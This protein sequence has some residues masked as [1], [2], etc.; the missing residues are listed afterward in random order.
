MSNTYPDPIQGANSPF[1]KTFSYEPMP[2][3]PTPVIPERSLR[4]YFAA[5]ALQAMTITGQ[6]TFSEYANDAY[7]LADAMLKA[8]GWGE[9]MSHLPDAGK[10]VSDTPRMD[11]VAGHARGIVDAAILDEG[12]KLERE[13]NAA[14]DRINRLEED[15]ESRW[16]LAESA[17]VSCDEMESR[18]KRLEEAGDA[19]ND[20]VKELDEK[21]LEVAARNLSNM[22]H[23]DGLHRKIERLIKAG[24]G[25]RAVVARDYPRTEFC[26]EW[27]KAK[28]AK[29]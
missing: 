6:Y 17:I 21:R 11:S 25:L 27:D 4:D 13:L 20:R 26:D 8:R 2:H 7:Q 3:Y 14:N 12:M 16:N 5:A 29:P 22:L 1:A 24:D 19:A 28:E 23:V 10:M 18:I 15:S 9:A